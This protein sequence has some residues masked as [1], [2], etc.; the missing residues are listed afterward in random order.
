MSGET[1]IGLRYDSITDQHYLSNLTS[2]DTTIGT[3]SVAALL[4]ILY[5]DVRINPSFYVINLLSLPLT[6]AKLT[7][8][9]IIWFN[10]RF[11]VWLLFNTSARY[12]AYF[13]IRFCRSSHSLTLLL[14][15][16]REMGPAP[17][18]AS[19]KKEKTTKAITIKPALIHTKA[20]VK[21]IVSYVPSFM[22]GT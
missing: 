3:V 15:L 6:L 21:L 16:V 14:F 18:H 12:L 4:K 22:I 1:F 10:V 7:N 13:Y 5:D 11:L 17:K 19:Q 2:T 8:N 9:E 20:Y